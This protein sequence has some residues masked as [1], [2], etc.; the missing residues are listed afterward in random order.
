MKN[1]L[2][3]LA[4]VLLSGCTVLMPATQ[5]ADEANLFKEAESSFSQERYRESYERYHTLAQTH[6]N[7]P[8]A[9]QAAFQA[10]F[11]LIYHKNPEKNYKQAILEFEAFQAAYPRSMLANE[12]ATWHEILIACDRSKTDELQAA[13]DALGRK[14]VVT[15]KELQLARSEQLASLTERDRLRSEN[16]ELSKKVNDILTEKELL[17]KEKSLMLHERDVLTK[18]KAALDIRIGALL[19]ERKHLLEA[20]GKLEKS[21]HDLRMVDVK[22]EKKRKNMRNEEKK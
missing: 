10:A 3:T 6:P 14:S 2:P 7:S 21:L 20:K 18:D 16:D 17:V 11:V 5:A 4:L 9:E 1:V 15:E 22:M 19:E 8:T 13:L 12:A